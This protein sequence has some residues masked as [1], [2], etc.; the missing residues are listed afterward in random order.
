MTIL[1]KLTLIF[2]FSIVIMITLGGL[3]LKALN[4][5]QDR[6]EYVTTNSMPSISKLSEGCYTGKRRGVRF[7]C[8]CW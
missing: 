2:I 8:H 6:F 1:K 4:N 7:S 5:A 3:S